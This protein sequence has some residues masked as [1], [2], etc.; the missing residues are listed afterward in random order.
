MKRDMLHEGRERI[1]TSHESGFIDRKTGV[2]VALV[3]LALAGATAAGELRDKEPKEEDTYSYT[4]RDCRPMPRIWKKVPYDI[5][6][7]NIKSLIRRIKTVAH[8]GPLEEGPCYDEALEIVKQQTDK[9]YPNNGT[10]LLPKF[11]VPEDM[12]LRQLKDD[13]Q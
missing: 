2:I 10:V 3:G 7:G 5:E 6:S 11:L 4:D 12:T 9:R 1:Q 13:L 8:E